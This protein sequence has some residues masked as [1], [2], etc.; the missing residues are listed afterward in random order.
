MLQLCDGAMLLSVAVDED[1]DTVPE[2]DELLADEDD[3]LLTGPA[4]T[5]ALDVDSVV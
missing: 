1:E 4:V 5:A 2:L 3:E